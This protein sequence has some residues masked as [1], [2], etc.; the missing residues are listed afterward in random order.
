M[1]A[2]AWPTI[3]LCMITKNEEHFIAQCINSV[4]ELINE[5]IVVDTGSNDKTVEIAKSFGAKVYFRAWDDDF[6]APRNLSIAKAS[7]DWI[8]VLDADEAIDSSDHEKLNKLTL[9]PSN[10]YLLTQRHYTNDARLSGFTPVK[11]EFPHW[12]KGMGGYFESSCVRLFPRHPGIEYRNRIHEL[13]EPCLAELKRYKIVSSGIR[14]HHYGH[15]REVREKKDKSSLYTSLGQKK[16]REQPTN[17]KVFFEMG[18]EHQVNG[19]YE[20]AIQAFMRSLEL[21]PK[22]LPTWI[23]LGYALG[24]AGRYQEAEQA[25]NTALQLNNKAHEAYCNLG[26]VYMRTERYY[27]AERCFIEAVRLNPE[28]INA[29]CNL[30]ETFMLLG[31]FEQAFLTFQKALQ[32]LPQCAKAKEGLGITYLML[33]RL[34]E[35]EKWLKECLKEDASLAGSYYWLSQVYRLTDRIQEAVQTLEKLS[36]AENQSSRQLNARAMQASRLQCEQLRKLL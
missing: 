6:S 26:V 17:W 19:R 20:Q 5:I 35:A 22:Y 14:I 29:Y 10:C 8:L 28:Y 15:I 7:G 4:K 1:P 9:N 21:L 27:F 24:E 3:S 13:V 32:L 34:E 25:L 11:G 36:Q 2:T 31:N 30:G 23:N 16:L 18:V 33:G 12:E